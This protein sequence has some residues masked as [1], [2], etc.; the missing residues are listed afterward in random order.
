M[1]DFARS[2][3]PTETLVPKIDLG[4]LDKVAAL[5]PDQHDNDGA[6]GKNGCAC[7]QGKQ[8]KIFNCRE[9]S[10]ITYAEQKWDQLFIKIYGNF[11]LPTRYRIDVSTRY[12]LLT[13]SDFAF[14]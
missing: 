8:A 7:S 3:L 13:Q 2:D 6:N 4:L 1:A 5:I 10:V 9:F 12:A 14:L 11:H